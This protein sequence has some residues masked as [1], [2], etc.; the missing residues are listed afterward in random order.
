MQ[1]YQVHTINANKRNDGQ[2]L[3]LGELYTPEEMVRYGVPKA[4][5][6]FTKLKQRKTVTLF[7][8]RYALEDIA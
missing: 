6:N 3:I 7:G 2:Q 5:V 1:F 8:T 4:N